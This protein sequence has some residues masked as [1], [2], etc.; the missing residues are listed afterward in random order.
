MYSVVRSVI[1]HNSKLS[2]SNNSYL[3]V[4]Q[5]DPSSSLLFMMFI[6]DIVTSV[7]T[8]IEGLF[9]IDEIELF[10]I[11]YADDQILFAKSPTSLQSMLNDI[12]IYCNTWDLKINIAKTK[13]LIFE[14][15]NRHTN[16]DFYLYNE[17]LEVVKSFKYLGVYFFKNRN[18]SRKQKC[19]AEYASKAMHRLFRLLTSMNLK[20]TKNVSFLI[21]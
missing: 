11:L 14:K 7:R 9:S 13:V 8:D 20:Q 15:S 2:N 16:Y 3:G 18:W 17:K 4:K 10:L 6:N 5:E 19:I 12:E 21:H 1:R